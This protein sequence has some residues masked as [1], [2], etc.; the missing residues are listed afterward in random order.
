MRGYPIVSSANV[1]YFPKGPF[2]LKGSKF[3]FWRLFTH[4]DIDLENVISFGR[5]V[6]G[7]MKMEQNPVPSS[8]QLRYLVILSG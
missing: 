1:L 5:Q 4:I 8:R 2:L 6:A 7:A 3:T